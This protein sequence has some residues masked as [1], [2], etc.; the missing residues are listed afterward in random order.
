M[1][2]LSKRLFSM[3]SMLRQLSGQEVYG[4]IG[5][6]GFDA[7]TKCFYDRVKQDDI[8]LPMYEQSEHADGLEAAQIRLSHYLIGRFGGPPLYTS[9]HGH[10]RLRARHLPFSI[11]ANARRRWFDSM[12]ESLEQIGQ[13]FD[14]PESA[15]SELAR[16]FDEMS[17]FM[18]NK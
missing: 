16:F 15:K 10:P 3:T 2:M 8:L 1:M 17:T 5:E 6:Q 12:D 13:E 4:Q 11:D 7:L 14:W 9:V 18:I